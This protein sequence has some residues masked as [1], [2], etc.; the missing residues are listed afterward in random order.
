MQINPLTQLLG[1]DS[2]FQPQGQQQPQS[3]SPADIFQAL[4]G[5][6]A[7][8]PS[9]DASSTSSATTPVTDSSS[10]PATVAN[11]NQLFQIQ[12]ALFARADVSGTDNG[13]QITRNT[14]SLELQGQLSEG[15]QFQVDETVTS[16]LLNP[17]TDAGSTSSIG[18]T[19]P[20]QDVT[21]ADGS[22]AS[23]ATGSNPLQDL[24][25]ALQ[26][27]ANLL[28][29]LTGHGHH[30]HHHS[31]SSTTD[32]QAASTQTGSQ[33]TAMD[34]STSY[35]SGASVSTV[36]PVTV[37]TSQTQPNQASIINQLA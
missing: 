35:S 10:S 21:P 29:S 2:V 37:D 7:A 28:Q 1:L 15:S 16:L 6:G 27:I 14:Q 4:T 30:H 17:S 33:T 23:P 20:A 22:A 9:A 31:G 3:P 13:F 32:T 25:Q 34:G 36:A 11:A 19:N 8:A 18:S 24:L 26:N 12:T 5:L